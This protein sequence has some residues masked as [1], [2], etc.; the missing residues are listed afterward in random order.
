[1]SEKHNFVIKGH[2]DR[3]G[4]MFMCVE[5][6]DS[7]PET[8]DYIWI[9]SDDTVY[10]DSENLDYLFLFLAQHDAFKITSYP[11]PDNVKS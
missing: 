7:E 11:Y 8:V 3:F 4:Q 5:C 1:M 9:D 10:Y 6:K 2:P